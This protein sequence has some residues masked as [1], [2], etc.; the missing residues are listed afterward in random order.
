MSGGYIKFYL[1]GMVK[2]SLKIH[3]QGDMC[4]GGGEGGVYYSAQSNRFYLCANYYF[5]IYIYQL[6]PKL[7]SVIT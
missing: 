2:I 6:T 3:I 5:R 4:G 7:V 1:S